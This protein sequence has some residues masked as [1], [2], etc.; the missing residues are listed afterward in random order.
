MMAE[1]S[2]DHD[3]KLPCSAMRR[4]LPP[5]AGI[6]KM[7][8]P[9]SGESVPEYK[10][11]DELKREET[12]AICCPSGEKAGWMSSA[13][14]LVRLMSGPPETCLRKISKLPVRSET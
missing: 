7:S 11:A 9:I 14:L 5:S 2:G 10:I 3:G 4:A 1:P 6:T 8:P 12:K 13:G